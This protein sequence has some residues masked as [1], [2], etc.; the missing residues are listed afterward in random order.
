ML[1]SE[2]RW[3]RMIREA[4]VGEKRRIRFTSQPH[5]KSWRIKG[6]LEVYSF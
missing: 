4:S 6:V 3:R 2:I 5:S 1:S